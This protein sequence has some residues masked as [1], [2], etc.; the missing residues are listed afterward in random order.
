[1]GRNDH[2]GE[3]T[4]ADDVHDG[5]GNHLEGDGEGSKSLGEEPDNRVEGPHDDGEPSDLAVEV[6]HV[7][8]LAGDDSLAEGPG[9]RI[10]NRE[11]H[12]HSEEEPEPLDGGD[13]RDSTHVARNDH[14]HVSSNHGS[15][16][17]EVLTSDKAEVKD[18]ERSSDEPVDIT[19]IEE[20]S[21]SSNSGPSLSREHSKVGEGGDTADE[22]VAEVELA[23]F[24]ISTSSLSNHHHGGDSKGKEAEGKSSDT[25]GSN[26]LDGCACCGRKCL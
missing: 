3:H 8:L 26:L 7:R 10:D 20:L 24:G 16:G 13:N 21:A 6:D 14:E 4:L 15:D 23:S 11:E 25:S 9:E 12:G 18:K 17:N 22:R 1:V 5:V 2:E 19:S